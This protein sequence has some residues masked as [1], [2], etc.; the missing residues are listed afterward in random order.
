MPALAWILALLWMA[1]MIYTSSLGEAATPL[2]GIMQMLA[3]K[4]GHVL[5]YAVLGALLTVA[6]RREVPA[7]WA[8]SRVLFIVAAIGLSFASFDELRQSFVPG[9][10]PRVTDVLLDLVS[11]LAGAA[12]LLRLDRELENK[13]RAATSR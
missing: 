13:E 3:S 6:V 8:W 11:V 12:G 4:L 7:G 2:G 1:G 9:R 5:E 10:E